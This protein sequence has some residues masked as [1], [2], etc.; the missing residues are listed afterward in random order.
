MKNLTILALMNALASGALAHSGVDSILPKD[1]ATLA[2][3]PSEIS[4]SFKG[5]IRLTRV[6]MIHQDNP[7]IRLDLSDQTS[8]TRVFSLPLD[9]KGEGI[10][11]IKWRG[12]G[13]DGHAMQGEFTFTVD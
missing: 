5:E 6:D 13:K 12:L 11:R 3:V 8:F 4:F 9:G 10:Y 7:A 1:G 2:E